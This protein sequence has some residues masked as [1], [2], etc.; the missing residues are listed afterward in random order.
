[1]VCV[2]DEQE[3]CDPVILF[4]IDLDTVSVPL[5]VADE[6]SDTVTV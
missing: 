4:F 1:M 3:L 5:L 2:A 6:E